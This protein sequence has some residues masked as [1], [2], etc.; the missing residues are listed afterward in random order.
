MA[1]NSVLV[2][3][4]A[5][6]N[7]KL[8]RVLLSRQGFDV[9]TA[10][11][12][13]EALEIVRDFRPRLVLADI[14]LPDMNGLELTRRLKSDPATRD[15]I[16]LALTAFAMQGDEERAIDAGCD[17]Y[18]TKPIDTRTF[19]ALIRR[20]LHP[21]SDTG[22]ARGPASYSEVTGD[23]L[24]FREL[25]Q[26]FLAEAIQQNARLISTL[27]GDFDVAEALIAAHRWVGAGGSIGYPEISQN[28]RELE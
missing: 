23:E 6:V 9:R 27:G 1:N 21:S 15:I 20:F 5:P 2:V 22:G 7:L 8:V 24:P 11:S 18:I 4:D 17:G 13:E 19:P 28:A 3:D 14:Q 26:G 12:A 25:Q 16:V 10:N